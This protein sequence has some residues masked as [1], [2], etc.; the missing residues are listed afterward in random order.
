VSSLAAA[1]PAM[2]WATLAVPAAACPIF[3]DISLV[4]AFCWLTASAI[5]AVKLSMS[6]MMAAIAPPSGRLHLG[7]LR[8]DLLGRLGGLDR[9]RLDLGSD[10][11][12]A[13][14][15]FAGPRRL[16]RG[17]QRQQVG[18]AGNVAD[19]ADH[20]VDM[21]RRG[22]Q[23]AH[24]FVGNAGH[25]G[26]ALHD[27]GGVVDLALDRLNG[28]AELAGGRCNRLHIVRCGIGR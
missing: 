28:L 19:E 27:R 6:F 20:F 25:A 21:L 1:V 26:R 14:P 13:A 18:L 16:D 10:H 4:A 5:V 24:G 11:R 9:Q 12:K 3:L 22:R 17:V 2:L 7:D 15:G 23:R 8:G